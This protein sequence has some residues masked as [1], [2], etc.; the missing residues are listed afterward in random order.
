VH[1]S[2][3]YFFHVCGCC[4]ASSLLS[5]P[6]CAAGSHFCT[7]KDLE[8]EIRSL[9]SEREGLEAV[10]GRLSALSSRTPWKLAG[11]KEDY[12]RLK[13]ELRLREAAHRE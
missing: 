5:P 4:K 1:W 13:R 2:C 12:S 3:S 7:A 6:P 8:E 11:I 9:T 10:L